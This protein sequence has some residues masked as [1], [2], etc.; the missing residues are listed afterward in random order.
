MSIH[1][2]GPVDWDGHKLIAAYEYEAPDPEVGLGA[3][4]TVVSLTINDSPFDA[5]SLIDPAVVQWIED[6]IAA[7]H[8]PDVEAL[9]GVTCERLCPAVNWAVLRNREAA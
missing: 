5:M 2:F 6:Q 8:A 4:Y 3:I 7:K 9:T 1:V